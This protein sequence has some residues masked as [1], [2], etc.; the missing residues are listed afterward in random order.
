[1]IMLI[2]SNWNLES[3]S[4]THSITH[5]CQQNRDPPSPLFVNI[6][7]ITAVSKPLHHNRY[8]WLA[9]KALGMMTLH[10]NFLIKTMVLNRNLKLYNTV[11]VMCVVGFCN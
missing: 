11:I 5:C 10:N 4:L 1:I 9:P 7:E 8:T 2:L 3:T 6:L